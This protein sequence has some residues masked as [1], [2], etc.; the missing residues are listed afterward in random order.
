MDRGWSNQG[1]V[2]SVQPR[3]I[4]IGRSAPTAVLASSTENS[5]GDKSAACWN[6]GAAVSPSGATCW[7]CGS[8]LG[9]GEEPMLPTS[10]RIPRG[11]TAQGS[12]GSSPSAPEES[13]IPVCEN[14]GATV[15]TSGSFCWKCGVPLETGRDPV[16]SGPSRPGGTPRAQGGDSRGLQSVLPGEIPESPGGLDGDYPGR[17]SRIFEEGSS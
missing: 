2:R 11:V 15:D 17:G 6:C 14:C 12:P 9:T 16:H 4:R 8:Q 7:K 13:E 3:F 1:T 5:L 10:E